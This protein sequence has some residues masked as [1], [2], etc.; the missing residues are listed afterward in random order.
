MQGTEARRP[1]VV[2]LGGGFAGIGAAREAR[3]TPTRTSCSSTS[4]TTTRSSRSSTRSRPTC[5]RPSAVGHPLRDLFHEQPNVAVHQAT[6]T[7]DR[8]RRSARCSSPRWRRSTY[9]YLVLGA[10]RRGQLLRHRGRR[11]ARLPDVHARRR[12]PPQGAR[13]PEVGGGGQGS[14]ARR[15]RRAQRR[16]RRRRPDR[17]RER[18]RAGRALPQ[19]LRQGLSE[20]AAGE[21]APRSSSRPGP[22]L[23]AMFK[24]DIRDLHEAGAREARRRGRPRESS[25]RR[26]RR[27]ASR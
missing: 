22:T 8:P 1:R 5:S 20:H 13:P 14:G 19:R 18:R 10:R 15:G 23:F 9:D 26:S 7:G 12:H 2:I 3:R 21:G 17:G 25:S 27:R 11:R 24:P 6:V 16:R 4:T